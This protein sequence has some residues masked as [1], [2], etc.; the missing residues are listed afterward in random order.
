MK[1]SEPRGPERLTDEDTPDVI[2]SVPY[3]GTITAV[4]EDRIIIDDN[5][6][7][8]ALMVYDDTVITRGRQKNLQA[9]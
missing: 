1:L 8:R 4:E 3:E 5:G 7:E 9:C 6:I 2:D